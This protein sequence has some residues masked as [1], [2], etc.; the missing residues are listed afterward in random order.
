MKKVF[1]FIL[2]AL[3]LLSCVVFSACGNK[4]KNLKIRIMSKEG[5][6][7][8]RVDFSIMNGEVDKQTI[9]VS[10]SGIDKDDVGQIKVSSYP[11]K[12]IEDSNY[13]YEG[14][15]CF[16]DILPLR[17]TKNQDAKLIVKHLASGKEANI[18]LNIDE[19]AN[20][21]QVFDT[22]YIVSIP[23]KIKDE[24]DQDV[25]NKHKLDFSQVSM[26]SPE[27]STDQIYFK[28]DKS[29]E[30]RG[31]KFTKIDEEISSK[32]EWV[33]PQEAFDLYTGFEVSGAA[34]NNDTISIYPVTIYRNQIN[35]IGEDPIEIKFK[36]VL[37]PENVE[38]AVVQ[39]NVE[40]LES[41]DVN[42]LEVIAN[43][44]Q[45]QSLI[46][47]LRYITTDD[48]DEIV[49]TPLV[50]TDFLDMYEIAP[51][52]GVD[53]PLNIVEDADKNIYVQLAIKTDDYQ[54][55][56]IQLVPKNY[57][58]DY[59]TVTK[60]IAVKGV[61]KANGIELYKNGKL[62][63][64]HVVENERFDIFN[65]YS[66]GNSLGTELSFVPY[67]N[68]RENVYEKL[69]K[70]QIVIKPEVLY[71]NK[72]K[73]YNFYEDEKFTKPSEY[74]TVENS[75]GEARSVGSQKY[76]IVVHKFNSPMKFYYNPAE[77]VMISEP[78][79]E[80]DKIFVKYADG[81]EKVEGDLSFTVRTINN[82]TEQLK[83]QTPAGV[84]NSQIIY[85]YP[86]W[87]KLEPTG[88]K[89][90]FNRQEGVVSMK[91][92]VGTATSV[93]SGTQ[94][95]T[96]KGF[97]DKIYLERTQTPDKGYYFI[98]PKT[99][100]VMGVV[101][102]LASA[103]FD[104]EVTPLF[105]NCEN[106]LTIVPNNKADVST[107]PAKKIKF[108]YNSDSNEVIKF[109]Y[110]STTSIGKYEIVF[111]QDENIKAKAVVMVYEVLS[112]EDFSIE[113]NIQ[114]EDSAYAIKNYEI[115]PD[116]PDGY[117]YKYQEYEM[118]YI[119][120]VGEKL[121][122]SVV[123]LPKNVLDSGI[124]SSYKFEVVKDPE[125]E[126]LNDQSQYIQTNQELG[127][128]CATLNFLKGTKT[129]NAEEQKY[130]NSCVSIK[131]T[132][133]Q[134]LIS[135]TGVATKP[136]ESVSYE[137][138]F[139]IYERITK[140]AISLSET[141]LTKYYNES[142]GVLYK[143]F[144][145]TNINI[146][147]SNTLSR[148]VTN[149]EWEQTRI[150]NNNKNITKLK[151]KGFSISPEFNQ[152]LGIL[153]EQ[154][155]FIVRLTQFNQT[156]ELRCVI[157]VKSAVLTEKLLITSPVKFDGNQ[158]CYIN[159][160]EGE[161][162]Q[163]TAEN[164][165]S[166]G[167]VTFPDTIIQVVD[168][169]GNAMVAQDYFEV[170]QDVCK[171]KVTNIPENDLDFKLIVF[172]K[173]VLKQFPSVDM[174]G[175]HNPSNF[176]M[177]S[178]G[179]DK[180]IYKNAY[181]VLGIELSNGTKDHP[182]LITSSEEFW[183]I[184][185]QEEYKDKYWRLQNNINLASDP[186]GVNQIKG[187]AGH[188]ST[189]P[190][191]ENNV[192]VVGDEPETITYNQFTIGNVK[193]T[194]KSLFTNNRG[195]INNITF[196]VEF[197]NAQLSGSV[198][199]FDVN[200]GT[201]T[202]V[203][204]V[205]VS[206]V[207]T[208]TS[209]NTVTR[210]GV[211]VGENAGVI[212]YTSTEGIVG[213]ITIAK[214]QSNAYIGGLVGYN[215]GT[216]VGCAP[217]GVNQ[218]SGN[219]YVIESSDVRKNALAEISITSDALGNDS[220]IGGL[221]GY[222]AGIICNGFVNAQI[223]APTVSNVGGV[224]GINQQQD[225][226]IGVNVD[227]NSIIQS[228]TLKNS[229]ISDVITASKNNAIYNV[230][231]TAN[232]YAKNNVGGITGADTS[233][234]YLDCDFQ[235]LQTESK[236]PA[237][238]GLVN[239]GG[240]AGKSTG[241]KFLYCST[242]SYKW[243]YANLKSN[244]NM[245]IDGDLREDILGDE[246]VGGIV[247]QAYST[248]DGATYNGVIIAY[249]SVNAYL[250]AEE[251]NNIGGIVNNSNAIT[252]A[253]IIFNAYFIG[254]LE[255]NV[256]YVK[257]V[258]TEDETGVCLSNDESNN[259]LFNNVYS[260]NIEQLNG[261][262]KI[263]SYKDGQSFNYQAQPKNIP[264]WGLLEG[265]NG[266]YI[267]VSI[268][269]NGDVPIFDRAPETLEV[270]VHNSYQKR[271]TNN[272]LITDTLFLNYYDFS[273]DTDLTE[274]QLLAIDKWYNRNYKI[275]KMENGHN[276]GLF[277]ITAHPNNLG[278]VVIKVSSSDSN[279]V[280]VSGDSLHVMGVGEC[281][282]TFSSVLNQDADAEIKVVVD[283][284][285][286]DSFDI[287]TLDGVVTKNNVNS[288]IAVGFSE[289]YYVKTSGTKGYQ[290]ETYS[291]RTQSNPNLEITIK[292]PSPHIKDYLE[293]SGF[294]ISE[295][296]KEVTLKLTSFTPFVISVLE[297]LA[298][299]NDC[300]TI[301]VKPY[302]TTKV[303]ETND[304]YVVY[305]QY[306]D[307][308]QVSVDFKLYTAVGPTNVAF[309]FDEA[310]IYPNDL[311]QIFAHIS[312]DKQLNHSEIFKML[313]GG[314]VFIMNTNNYNFEP[315]DSSDSVK[316]FKILRT[317]DDKTYNYGTVTIAI[318]T[319]DEMNIPQGDVQIVEFSIQYERASNNETAQVLSAENIAELTNELSFTLKIATNYGYNATLK[320]EATADFTLIP[321]KI[322]NFDVKNY[323]YKNK[324]E[325]ETELVKENILKSNKAGVIQIDLVP[326][327]GYYSY[328]EISDKTGDQEILFTQVDNIE[329]GKMVNE[330]EIP[331]SDKTG[332][333]LTKTSKTLYVRTQI[334]KSYNSKMH[335][336]ELR[337]YSAEDKL[338]YSQYH[339]LDVK[340]LPNITMEYLNPNGSTAKKAIASGVNA[341]E[342]AEQ[343]AWL[344]N[345]VDAEFR[346]K[347]ENSNT[348]LEH[349]LSGDLKDKYEFIHDVNDYYVLKR[350]SLEEY[351][352]SPEDIN[353]KVKIHLSTRYEHENGDV[354]IAECS[355]EFT[356]V[357][358]VIH[359]ISVNNSTVNMQGENEIYGYVGKNVKLEFYFGKNDIS[360]YDA[361]Q[362]TPFWNTEYR[363][364]IVIDENNADYNQLKQ[365]QTILKT[366]NK[367]EKKEENNK[368]DSSES[369]NN[370]YSNYVK[371]IT[372]EN[373][374]GKI[375]FTE[376]SFN[377]LK[378]D[379]E[380]KNSKLQI[381]FEVTCDD[382]NIWSIHALTDS[383]DSKYQIQKTYKLNFFKT[384]SWYD[385]EIIFNEQDF[386]EME[387]GKSYILA[388]D[389]TFGDN[390]KGI[391]DYN[392]FVPVDLDLLE[393]DGNGRK[394]TIKKFAPFKN[395]EIQAGL[396]A[397]VYENMIVKNVVVEYAGEFN[398]MSNYYY[399]LCNG[400][401][402]YSLAN[403]GGIA[404][405][406]NGI[407]TNCHVEG[408]VR[409][410]ASVIEQ[411]KTENSSSYQ[412]NMFIGGV[413]V[414]NSKTG[415]ITNSTSRLNI[416]SQA[417]IG[418]FVHTNK[419]KIASSGVIDTE[420]YTYNNQLENTFVIN[421]AGFAVENTGEISMSYVKLRTVTNPETSK[422]FTKTISAKDISAGFAYSN[423]GK[424]YD[425]YVEMEKI[426]FNNNAFAGFVYSNA[427]TV[428][429]AYT[430]INKGELKNASDSLF[431]P[432]ETEGLKDCIEFVLT[433]YTNNIES[434]LEQ[435]MSTQIYNKNVYVESSFAFGDNVS[436]V[437]TIQS[438]SM[439]TLVAEQ[440]ISKADESSID[441]EGIGG[442]LSFIKGEPKLDETTG[443][444]EI[445]YKV[446][447]ANYG[448]KNNPYIIHTAV[449]IKDESGNVIVQNTW[450]LF[451]GE[452]LNLSTGETELIR[453]PYFRIVKDIDFTEIGN[454]PKTFDRS[455]NGN[456]QGNNMILKNIMLYSVEK[457]ESI[458]LFKE[459]VGIE[460]L[461]VEN[462]VRN[463]TLTTSSV[464]ASK[465]QAVGLL[466]GVI[467]DFNLYN[468]TI[469]SE[470][471][472]MVGGNAV[473]GIAGI[474]RGNFDLDSLSSNIGINSNRA[475][476]LSS[477]SIYMGKNNK[478]NVSENLSDVYYAG[479][480][481]GI[482]DGFDRSVYSINSQRNTT[483]NFFKVKN[484]NVTGNVI[485]LGDS[486]GAAF[487]FIGERTHVSRVN[488][489]ISGELS[490]YQYSG[491]LAG[492][493]RGVIDNRIKN[494]E[495]AQIVFAD[496]IFA[497]S[498]NVSAGVVGLNIGGLVMN[499]DVVGNIKLNGSKMAGGIVGKNI[500]GV[501]ANTY[502]EGEI[503]AYIVG[504]AVAGD[505][506]VSMFNGKT[507]GSGAISF[508]NKSNVN[509]IPKQTIKYENPN[510]ITDYQNISFGAK[511]IKFW[512]DNIK[513]FYV[514]SKSDQ[515]ND[516][517][518]EA[519]KLLGLIVGLTGYSEDADQVKELRIESS[520]FKVL[521]DV[522]EVEGV[523]TF[524]AE[525]GELQ[526][527][528]ASFEAD[529]LGTNSET[530]ST[531]ADSESSSGEGTT[532]SE[533][534]DP[535]A[536]E[537]NQGE[538]AEPP[539]AQPLM[540]TYENQYQLKLS[541]GD[542]ELYLVGALSHVADL[543]NRSY[544]Q[545]FV[546][547]IKTS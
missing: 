275:Y 513:K 478:A 427:G 522:E 51:Q 437:W 155:I 174:S 33:E 426:G 27:T 338:L 401:A 208:L 246:Y 265:I 91:L 167:A 538:E 310:I 400:D 357:P 193:I 543:W 356:I 181:F 319:D 471:I 413:V 493:N 385:P 393:F 240:I 89:L 500:N 297:K 466:A 335:T 491:V 116:S 391:K 204:V 359:D 290:G 35:V 119:V 269:E 192:A 228:L 12:L 424:I 547:L 497:N 314:Q 439:P 354:D 423:N 216:I 377:E 132:V 231:S 189:L 165:S 125:N 520:G 363:S 378:I 396:F 53:C 442:L 458:G 186:S 316:K 77:D 108:T 85:K 139:F 448:T 133:Q 380:I 482:L 250:K 162:Y 199:L 317:Q 26:L 36:K 350:K 410:R 483:K 490:G 56:E 220:A 352:I 258:Q 299:N 514:Y 48:N 283:Y 34:E 137:L 114:L 28:L 178:L 15:S 39:E 194:N 508:Q 430:Y 402:N 415:Y 222:N 530:A 99:N 452:I 88:I 435:V 390:V 185:D 507:N 252:T 389:L 284:P 325:T 169:T 417:N 49:K 66:E 499:V 436:A 398:S 253:T 102:E 382:D 264:Y 31:V 79:T 2:I 420:I 173:D 407:I 247:G 459:M 496:D 313:N 397:K 156:F 429:R 105:D 160:K 340:M 117:S 23:E 259:I 475:T 103:T 18:E 421:V 101:G 197:K 302:K 509:L 361:T 433:K 462:A 468:I 152:E 376:S 527:L 147:I 98:Q 83:V 158:N 545:N 502:Y 7:I 1:S 58:G 504:G 239:V 370:T 384:T 519:V 179:A 470:N 367:R 260:I 207:I 383:A 456:I 333:K 457:Q 473:G 254:R 323:Y 95:E 94:Y 450:Q 321:Q 484:V 177:E 307:S 74:T 362:P 346:I 46:L 418:G 296:E 337:A 281:W 134:Q 263:G 145:D 525:N 336:I 280:R 52:M 241:G 387:A 288:S 214:S 195:T 344:A 510:K 203:G 45:F 282:L 21:I 360:F 305:Y 358:F 331:S 542:F 472:I 388:T 272:T 151:D 392:G 531:Q 107:I 30:L 454:N 14:K 149:I 329:N 318:V 544:S 444:E 118:H 146:N 498:A 37:T 63:E 97:T 271:D 328:L 223:S 374:N 289:E 144:A 75:I 172:A 128:N 524:N 191:Q 82:A 449:D 32:I 38:L 29:I 249:S 371:L 106:P 464:W 293:V 295:K 447:N 251:G 465:T 22:T 516:I 86:H 115:N 43:D 61:L 237:L 348:D 486:V 113:K 488:I 369:E 111:K 236:Q 311:V 127:S 182:Y 428:E 201:L 69:N 200:E 129:Y 539:V 536:G 210:F 411:R 262:V 136:N 304:E 209:N 73:G 163:V 528:V 455:F 202:D 345:G 440:E 381:G 217:E 481:A 148:Y 494:D 474:I 109:V 130:F 394:I 261:N 533:T 76:V 285:I 453:N 343:D 161:E 537:P 425:A 364:N 196:E 526:D 9:K 153:S 206:G 485:L 501:V 227:D 232:I 84:E 327:N 25:I 532:G 301:T 17:S 535:G 517:Q 373:E 529:L 176:I 341:E 212:K 489:N 270:S 349:S 171:I 143:D 50:E 41:L 8:E 187:F 505:Y 112:K 198:G 3:T 54:S 180:N 368:E 320:N 353:K 386:F 277:D 279:V 419:G 140:D 120:A 183:Q 463:L 460:S 65:Y 291:Y 541:V 292:S 57:V 141:S 412:T 170:K 492:E 365:I 243:S 434:G 506:T 332:I 60:T 451:T 438:G 245:V 515:S 306:E 268:D 235:I 131:V 480:V 339:Y 215:T 175:Y 11:T 64:N 90:N 123:N 461:E 24:N 521:G 308:T 190:I 166:F 298:N 142:L 303:R 81:K 487:G 255:G 276:V 92:A 379:S 150:T 409:L 256:V 188:L 20:G 184:D 104:V 70:M 432:R 242:M 238:L 375:K 164:I 110:D 395:E 42:K 351:A 248:S 446:S 322:S 234:L 422:T 405:V 124:I 100:S 267:F 416:N 138:D 71:Y 441:D 224:I 540:K 414:E 16:V 211:L 518:L 126:T 44:N 154:N 244:P 495:N 266:D 372:D 445:V 67:A 399:D 334:D 324:N 157:D 230:K 80:I 62:V 347:I 55:A 477:Y 59:Q 503:F 4:Y 40:G 78:F 366:L 443:K 274:S 226:G 511:T 13:R 309:S 6:V 225:C 205:D 257:R 213:S 294:L 159:L 476:G 546:V 229:A 96:D 93:D 326:D 19:K 342:I 233:G 278:N 406:N 330:I 72:E 355:F 534:T 286:G 219:Q 10:F 479:S 467:E 218:T 221:V 287:K 404:A 168:G 431:A 403:F 469:N 135:L 300:F 408:S 87:A 312:T 315:C 273:I 512:I 121:K 523:I 122:L 5:E 68:S 47:Q